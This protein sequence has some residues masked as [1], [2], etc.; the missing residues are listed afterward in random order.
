[1]NLLLN[2]TKQ[3]NSREPMAR[4]IPASHWL[5]A[6]VV[7]CSVVGWGDTA[8]ADEL[9]T[10]E[11]YVTDDVIAIAY[12][13]LETLDLQAA[14]E[15]VGQ[16]DLFEQ[17][18]RAQMTMAAGFG[19]QAISALKQQGASRVMVL[20]RHS[21]IGFG[22]PTWLVSVALEKKA[23]TLATLLKNND[24]G[25]ILKLS[26]KYEMVQAVENVVLLATSSEQLQQMQQAKQ[27][28]PG[29]LADAWKALGRGDAGF[30]VLGDRDSRRVVREMFPKLPEPLDKIDGKLIGDDLLWGG[31]S[32]TLPP[33]PDLQIVV[34]TSSEQTASTMQKAAARALAVLKEKVPANELFQ[35]GEFDALLSVLAPRVEGSRL[36]IRFDHLQTDL[37]RLTQLLKPPVR[38]ARQQ[39]HRR[40]RMNQFKNIALA[41]HNYY[42]RHKTL[43]TNSYNEEGKPLLSWR[44]HIL[45]Y[46]E[47][48]QAI[49]DQFHLDEPWDSE[50]NR[51]LIEKMPAIYADPD[52]AMQAINRQ[53]KTIFLVPVG[54]KLVFQGSTAATF[55]EIT[56]GTSNT[57]MLVE[58]APE[59]AV[60]WTQ[61]EDWQ[62]DLK[63][64]WRGVRRKD[65]K[66][67]T[68]A[69]CD[70]G[71][72]I[73][74]EKMPA[75][76][77]RSLLTPAGGEIIDWP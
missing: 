30:I 53:G 9:A 26:V 20:L 66:W 39:A 77:L 25:Q 56:D 12:V 19:Q 29:A 54:E 40:S 50:H 14:A 1:M 73:L 60:V 38:Q 36:V 41:F 34:Q 65:R 16:L 43:P 32:I 18:D 10:L 58:V 33:K 72:R 48:G 13:N 76:T 31:I 8:L 52:S 67:F 21:D 70:G 74:D 75:K 15:W 22:G 51:P 62:V 59:R 24:L 45:P 6:I 28:E 42:D 61:P 27:R 11:R 71:A 63:D 69:Y 4:R 17:H 37:R 7:V 64:P 47:S 46:L 68:A 44:V 49:Y 55:R 5:A 57:I 3:K 23:S 35:E 2:R